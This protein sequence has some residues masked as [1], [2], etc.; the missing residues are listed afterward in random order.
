M[1]EKKFNNNTSHHDENNGMVWEK[2]Q[3]K[4][5][6]F[7]IISSICWKISDGGNRNE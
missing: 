1:P 7:S 4:V 2:E 3:E 5:D 6:N